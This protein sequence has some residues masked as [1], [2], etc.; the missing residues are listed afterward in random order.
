MPLETL[1]LVDLRSN[2]C[3]RGFSS[4]QIPRASEGGPIRGIKLPVQFLLA[5]DLRNS[6]ADR[7]RTSSWMN[8]SRS[9]ASIPRASAAVVNSERDFRWTTI[10]DPDCFD[11]DRR[12]ASSGKARRAGQ[13]SRPW[14]PSGR[15]SLAA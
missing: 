2:G 9:K 5:G 7:P 11:K 14:I 10:M 8:R 15:R 13:S 4:L 6:L 3:Q 12:N 1:D